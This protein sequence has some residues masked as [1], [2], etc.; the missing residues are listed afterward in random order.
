[1]V[2]S[3]N[4]TNSACTCARAHRRRLHADDIKEILL[5]QAIYCGVPAANHA[6]RK[7]Q[8]LSGAGLLRVARHRWSEAR[9]VDQHHDR[10]AEQHQQFGRMQPKRGGL[11][12]LRSHHM[13]AKLITLPMPARSPALRRSRRSCG[14]RARAMRTRNIAKNATTVSL[15]N[16]SSQAT[17]TVAIAASCRW[18]LMN[19][20]DRDV[21][22]LVESVDRRHHDP[23]GDDGPGRN[24]IGRQ[25]RAVE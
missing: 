2:R 25:Q 9:D 5:Q 24:E 7:R 23:E 22:P 1:M 18:S 8:R 13:L 20:A 12:D 4:G 6:S 16:A 10:G 19:N 3:A 21:R 14:S 15:P 17:R 11:A